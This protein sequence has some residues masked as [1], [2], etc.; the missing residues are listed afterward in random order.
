MLSLSW[1]NITISLVFLSILT[2]VACNSTYSEE[3]S[4]KAHDWSAEA[5]DWKVDTILS[6]EQTAS[7]SAEALKLYE[8]LGM[9]VNPKKNE[10][11]LKNIYKFEEQCNGSSIT[12]EVLFTNEKVFGSYLLLEK[13]DTP[14]QMMK[15]EE[16]LNK[17]CNK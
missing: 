17:Y 1:R 10:A 4:V 6:E 8:S 15:K 7:T 11:V 16:F 14:I 9:D 5:N 13:D 12:S 3:R 2:L